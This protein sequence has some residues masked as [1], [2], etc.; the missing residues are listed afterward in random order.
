MR[1]ERARGRRDEP[2]V[3]IGRVDGEGPR[4]ASASPSFRLVPAATAVSAPGGAVAAS[5]VGTPWSARMP[6]QAMHVTGR[7]RAMVAEGGAAVISA[8][9]PTELD[10]HQ[11]DVGLVRTRR[12]PAH[13]RRPRP[14]R[15]AP[16]RPRRDVL[17]R[18]Q[19]LPALAAVAAAEHPA[20]LRSRVHGA[21]RRTYR[22]AEHVPLWQRHLL[23]G[24]APVS[25]ALQSASPTSH[26]YRLAVVRQ[27]LRPR[28]L[29]PRRRTYPHKRVTRRRNQLHRQQDRASP[30]PAHP[31]C[32]PKLAQRWN[33]RVPT[34]AQMSLPVIPYLFLL[35]PARR[36]G[37]PTI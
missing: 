19:L 8:H 23:E 18:H 5:L 13:V 12:D 17:K 4:V 30:P 14:R 35:R 10:A 37:T 22:D 6:R 31:R 27:T 26:V 32:H 16:L 36:S 29:Q 11:H 21:I 28:T 3:G 24:V 1:L 7:L 20:G 2:A 9:Q 15:K 34:F 25:A 33:A